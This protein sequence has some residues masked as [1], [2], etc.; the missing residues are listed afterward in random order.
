MRI[1][2]VILSFFI[3]KIKAQS[4]I[5]R[6]ILYYDFS[7]L[8]VSDQCLANLNIVRNDLENKEIWALKCK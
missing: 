3:W 6:K 2:I 1:I 8:T 4:E 5:L 7:N